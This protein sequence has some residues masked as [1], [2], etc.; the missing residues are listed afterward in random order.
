MVLVKNN[1]TLVVMAVRV[2]HCSNF[3]HR[4][5]GV[6]TQAIKGL[7]FRVVGSKWLSSDVFMGVVVNVVVVVLVVVIKI[8]LAI[9]R[10]RQHSKFFLLHHLLLVPT[11]TAEGEKS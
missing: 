4:S 10:F 6:E 9:H 3:I 8:L 7:A 11:A 2:N 5:R 1:L